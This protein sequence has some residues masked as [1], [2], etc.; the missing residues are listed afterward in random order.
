MAAVKDV[1]GGG[2]K[3]DRGGAGD[4]IEVMVICFPRYEGIGRCCMMMTAIMMVVV[5]A[6]TMTA[7]TAV[8]DGDDRADS[9]EVDGCSGDSLVWLVVLTVIPLL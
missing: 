2:R 7:V 6:V 1:E 3:S 9:D 8:C 4:H 5:I